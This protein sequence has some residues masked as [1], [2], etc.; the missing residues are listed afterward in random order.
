MRRLAVIFLMFALL[1]LT[2]CQNSEQEASAGASETPPQ[3]TPK[4]SISITD[5]PT[6]TPNDIALS[7][8]NRY[9]M[10]FTLDAD[11]KQISGTINVALKNDSEDDWDSICFRDYAASVLNQFQDSFDN[12]EEI[13]NSD[14]I[15]KYSARTLS[16]KIT[17][18]I[19]VQ[20]GKSL[21]VEALTSDP[22][23]LFVFLE[24]PLQPNEEIEIEMKY[25]AD[26]P[27]GAYRYAYHT[28]KNGKTSF[29]LGNFYP[30]LAVYEN[31][32]WVAHPYLDYGE[33]FYSKC[34]D[35][36]VTLTVP[37]GYAVIASGKEERVY[38]NSS[39]STWEIRADNMRDLTITASNNLAKISGEIDGITVNSYYFVEGDSDIA[40]Y[41]N[42]K[43]LGEA[44]LHAGLESIRVFNQ[45]YGNYPYDELDIVESNLMWGGME[46]PAFV[47]IGS[48]LAGFMK[49][50]SEE[51]LE[52]LN[53]VLQPSVENAVSHE[54]A[55]QWFCVVIGNDSYAE[56]WLDESFAD[57][58][59][60]LFKNSYVDAYN[61][62]MDVS[63]EAPPTYINLP[64]EQYNYDDND[65]G[66]VVYGYGSYFLYRLCDMFGE[67]TFFT[68][69]HEYYEAFM[70][71]E[72]K[73]EDFLS[74]IYE[75][76][77]DKNEVDDL[78]NIYLKSD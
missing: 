54:V 27:P 66:Q 31:G 57:F 18:V 21:N 25:C 74:F 56:S 58:S 14:I 29:E 36:I 2:S 40:L 11:G 24:T 69:M 62:E 64:L 22:S 26:I 44:A 4:S 38:S 49:E 55:H 5:E 17:E 50:Y 67:E 78:M 63:L 41:N 13:L 16:S 45:A 7:G 48:I 39:I 51:E 20:T 23:V 34:S 42:H 43:L 15:E 12:E 8:R 52:N 59:K 73:T 35:Y 61:F 1:C 28:F 19:D 6:P 9:T 72:A 76:A 68:M 65:Y 71:K 32:N 77:P 33:S 75:F 60:L 30:I 53:G 47:R 70:F 3:Q 10:E 37:E 46:Y